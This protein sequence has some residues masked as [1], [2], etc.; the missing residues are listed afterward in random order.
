M[1]GIGLMESMMV[2]E[3][4]RGQEEAGIEGS[5]DKDLDMVLECTGF[6]QEMFMLGNGQMD[7]AMDVEFIHVKMGV[8]M[9]GN[10]SGVLS[11]AL[12]STISGMAIHMLVSILQI[13]CMAL[14]FMVLRMG[15]GTRVLGMKVEG[16]GWEC[17]PSEMVK[18]NV[19]TGRMEFWISQARSRQPNPYLLLLFI[20]PKYS[21]LCRKPV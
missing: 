1:K 8:D 5:I 17:M 13:R 20:I 15:T 9:L 19:V 4:R 14:V 10:S 3:L 16:K 2:L 18:P 21:M 7:R 12:D 11:T 6:I